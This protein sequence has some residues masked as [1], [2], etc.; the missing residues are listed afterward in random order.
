MRE[1]SASHTALIVATYRARETAR[2]TALFQDP[3]AGRLVGD[4]GQRLAEDHDALNPFGELYVVVRTAYLDGVVTRYAAP[5][6]DAAQVVLLGAGFDVRAA[7]LASPGVRFFEVD[8]PD[9]QAEKLRRL[10]ALDGYP[11]A[12]ATYVPCDFERDDFFDRLVD[13]GFD[14]AAPAVFIWE[15]VTLYLVEE[16]VRKTLA[17]VASAAHPGSVL[18]FD[19]VGKK[20]VGGAVDAADAKL[21]ESFDSLGEPLRFG[22]DDVLPLLYDA[23]F[24]H[25]RVTSF[26]EACLHFTE[27][28]ERRRKFRFQHMA[29]ASRGPVVEP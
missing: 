10:R 17:R 16:A 29:L 4:D 26:D 21:R 22:T 27:T 1:G 18:A 24:R 25:V 20:M 12:A 9:T 8:Q 15:G 6:G 19:F 13:A 11:I 23:G 14:A 5:R 7:R 28:Y 2:P 3:W